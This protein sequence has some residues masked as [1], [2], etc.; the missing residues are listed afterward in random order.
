MF[1]YDMFY[2]EHTETDASED[3]E[4]IL[5]KLDN[6]DERLSDI[7]LQQ[8]NQ[9]SN[10]TYNI[11]ESNEETTSTQT[12]AYLAS[13]TDAVTDLKQ[14]VVISYTWVICLTFIYVIFESKKL[15]R[16]SIKRWFE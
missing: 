8:G 11:S 10:V 9:K 12:D 13:I 2:S 14:E 16:G 4:V 5:E 15:L 3:N 6:I 7:Q 1:Y